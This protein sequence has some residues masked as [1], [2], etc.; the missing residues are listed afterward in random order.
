MNIFVKLLQLNL[1]FSNNIDMNKILI[2]IVFI[3]QACSPKHKL[4]EAEWGTKIP[5]QLDTS[6]YLENRIPSCDKALL[7]MDSVI[8][9]SKA[10]HELSEVYSE[11][12]LKKSE[13]KIKNW[14]KYYINPKCFIGKRLELFTKIFYENVS[15]A[16]LNTFY[17]RQL[18]FIY[19]DFSL[20]I[21]INGSGIIENATFS[22]NKTLITN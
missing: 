8:I 18:I 2:I 20:F 15:N 19:D 6:Q 11:L 3:V 14:Y 10:L 5:K 7:Y 16:E 17:N 12:L 4:N 9:P 13:N 21:T 1:E 22:E